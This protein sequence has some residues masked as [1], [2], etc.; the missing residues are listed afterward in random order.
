LKARAEADLVSLLAEGFVAKGQHPDDRALARRLLSHDEAERIVAGMLREYLGARPTAP[1]EA[2]AA[3]RAKA[4]RP[5]DEPGQDAS[6]RRE[7]RPRR[8]REDRGERREDR[9][10]RREARSDRREREERPAPS[11]TPPSP[12]P[13]RVSVQVAIDTAGMVERPRSE[14]PRLAE[15]KP[16]ERQ[17]DVRRSEGRR[18]DR[19]RERSRPD[20][21]A[22][23]ERRA[24]AKQAIDEISRWSPPEEEGDDEPLLPRKQATAAPGGASPAGGAASATAPTTSAAPSPAPAA[25]TDEEATVELFLSVGRRD[26]VKATELARLLSETTGI[27]AERVRRVRVRDRN[28]FVALPPE[29]ARTAVEKLHGTMLAGRTATVELAR[30]RPAV[31]EAEPS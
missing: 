28:S 18:D 14:D 26:G 24:R 31:S 3:R 16:R 15:A 11:E 4:P 27:P 22:R 8:E 30:E 5:V 29:F 20:D 6:E 23:E 21:A 7:R 9:G 13:D 17:D 1:E 2:G 10:E 25:A 12:A 19:R